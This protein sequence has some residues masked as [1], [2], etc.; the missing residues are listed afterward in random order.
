MHTLL[1]RGSVLVMYYVFARLITCK[2]TGLGVYGVK[3]IGT[4]G[5]KELPEKCQYIEPQF[6]LPR[7]GILRIYY[8]SSKCN[9]SG[10]HHF[11][12]DPCE[13]GVGM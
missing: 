3:V 11:V 10:G 6:T 13:G 4:M 8:C 9:G 1:Q 7:L 12:V 5:T 2:E